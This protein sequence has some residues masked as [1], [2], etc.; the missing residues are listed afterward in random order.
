MT[1]D[2]SEQGSSSVPAEFLRGVTAVIPADAPRVVVKPTAG[3][4]GWNRDHNEIRVDPEVLDWPGDA[5]CFLGAHE[6][7]HV[8]QT[9]L[10]RRARLMLLWVL[11]GCL[12]VSVLPAIVTGLTS[13]ALT[14]GAEGFVLTMAL[15]VLMIIGI[16]A[17]KRRLELAADR[18]AA[19]AVGAAGM[20]QWAA[21][22]DRKLSRVARAM[23][24]WNRVWGLT[25][26]P[27]W[28]RRVRAAVQAEHRCDPAGQSR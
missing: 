7:A 24:A 15:M 26:H 5:Q 9:V 18:S 8:E 19:A 25:T 14:G 16:L 10:S 3:R 28:R 23:F 4:A 13:D 20:Q 21:I 22:E 27:S 17:H 2:R 11:A 6:A 1:S 12:A